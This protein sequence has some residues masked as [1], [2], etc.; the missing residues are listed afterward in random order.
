MTTG[1]DASVPDRGDLRGALGTLGNRL[2]A[3]AARDLSGLGLP[4]GDSV[5][6]VVVCAAGDD[7]LDGD[8][9]V[10]M[11][12]PE[13]AIPVAVVRGGRLPGWVGPTTVVVVVA[14]AR[15]DDRCRHVLDAAVSAGA[16][17]VVITADPDFASVAVVAGARVCALDPSDVAPRLL[18]GVVLMPLLGVFEAI[19]V[20]PGAGGVVSAAFAVAASVTLECGATPVGRNR[21]ETA[22]LARRIGRTL[23]LVYG[24]DGVPGFAAKWWKSAVNQSAKLP[25]FA[26]GVPSMTY[27]EFSMFGQAGDLT[28]Q[29][30]TMVLLRAPRD[31]E[32]TLAAGQLDR[33]EDQFREVVADVSTI[34]TE[35][36]GVA[37]YLDLAIR[38]QWVAVELANLAGV[39]PSTVSIMDDFWTTSD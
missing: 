22:T 7:A 2:A 38:G 16:D 9:A 21:P 36:R 1:F 26:D 15:T 27:S 12:A 10:A 19:G 35:A 29:V 30:F 4:S 31:V 20:F 34:T 13:V 5:T 25:A 11:V 17:V 37:A 24:A 6:G 8:F 14:L 23:P 32:G 3:L 39:D 18:P 33:F 28:R